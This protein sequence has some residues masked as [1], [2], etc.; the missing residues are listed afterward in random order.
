MRRIVGIALAVS[1]I[2]MGAG[3][4]RP[5]VARAQ[6]ESPP[7]VLLIVTD[8]Q[9]AF[10]TLEYMPKLMKRIAGRGVQFPRAYATTPQC[11]P[12][13]ASIMT[14][15]YAHNHGV[16]T[17]SQADQLDH[18]TTIQRN[19][20][21]AGYRT[22]LVGKFLNEWPLETPPPYF[23]DYTLFNKGYYRNRWNINGTLTASTRYSTDFIAK[24]ARSFIKESEEDDATPW[25][26]YVTPWA[27]HKSSIPKPRYSKRDVGRFDTNAAMLERD[28]SDKLPLM[29]CQFDRRRVARDRQKMLRTLLSVDDLVEK[30]HRTLVAEDELDNTLVIFMS[31]NGYMWGEHGFVGKKPPYLGGIEIPMTMAWPGNVNRNYIDDRLVANIDVAPTIYDAAGITPD[32]TMDGRSLLDDTW[33]RSRL[34]LEYTSNR[35]WPDWATTLTSEDQYI[36]YYYESAVIPFVELYRLGS[37]PWELSNVVGDTEPSNDPSP[38]EMARLRAQLEADRRCAGATCP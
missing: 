9:R 5:E 33:S 29:D 15:Q 26:L 34:L 37:D 4:S 13:R 19:L 6:T 20:S 24:H 27:P 11:C 3:P 14:G 36:E 28:C 1:L 35:G 38:E 16:R 7:N 30:V 2:G 12:S 18:S 31:D 32:H 23:D 22:G 8:D 10:G 21:D 25:Y 17:N